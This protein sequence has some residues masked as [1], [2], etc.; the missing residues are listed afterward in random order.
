[1]DK[2]LLK[3]YARLRYLVAFL[4][5]K[6]QFHWW[7]SSLLTTT[8]SRYHEMLFPRTSQLSTTLSVTE[9]ASKA[10]DEFLGKNR[11]FHLFRLPTDTEEQL[12]SY[13]KRTRPSIDGLDKET[14]LKELAAI[15]EGD[16]TK[17]EG[18]VKIAGRK[19]INRSKSIASVAAYYLS[20]FKSNTKCYPY[21]SDV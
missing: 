16:E 1:M 7:P 21:F 12:H 14:A 8:G 6:D 11:S 5:E 2:R 10:H 19:Q 18:P 15:A 9:I 13:Y 17:A 20:A 4:G 3:T